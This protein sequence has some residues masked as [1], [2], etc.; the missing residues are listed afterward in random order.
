LAAKIYKEKQSLPP[1]RSALYGE[2][3]DRALNRA[4]E[5]GLNA[6]L[7]DKLAAD[8]TLHELRLAYLAQR[9]TA[10]EQALDSESIEGFV[11]DHFQNNE[12][13]P[14]VLAKTCAK[15]WSE[16]MGRCSG[17][18][19]GKQRIYEFLH[20]TVREYL[21]AKYLLENE[22]LQKMLQDYW[23]SRGTRESWRLPYRFALPH[24]M[25]QQISL[26]R[27]P[28]LSRTVPRLTSAIRKNCLLSD[29]VRCV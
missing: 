2:L 15:Q 24:P 13:F 14:R 20:S 23:H 1:Q 17:L 5:N 25:V 19:I 26:M 16:R 6:E 8:P 11:A 21:A 29:V 18:L 27:S 9:M 28:G 12:G 7:G 10:S 22:G 3:V 4:I